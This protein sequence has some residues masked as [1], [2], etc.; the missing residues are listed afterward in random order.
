VSVKDGATLLATTGAT[1]NP[2]SGS[3]PPLSFSLA[4]KATHALTIN[5]CT[6]SASG[7]L[8]LQNVWV[9]RAP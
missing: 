6:S 2:P 5:Y 7:N 1:L 9:S 3:P 8:A 4:T